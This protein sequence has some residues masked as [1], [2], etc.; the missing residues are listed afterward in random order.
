MS[1]ERQAGWL[2]VRPAGHGRESGFYFGCNR[3]LWRTL[4]RGVSL[5]VILATVSTRG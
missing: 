3:K 1:S 2:R 4:N 5:K